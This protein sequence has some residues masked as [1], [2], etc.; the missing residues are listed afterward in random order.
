MA[1][2]LRIF[3]ID[4]QHDRCGD[5]V[6]DGGHNGL[7]VSSMIG[8]P[9]RDVFYHLEDNWPDA[10]VL[11]DIPEDNILNDFCDQ[12]AGCCPIIL[13]VEP[14][15]EK[16]GLQ[17][18]QHGVDDL[19]FRD[20]DGQ[21]VARL[22]FVIKK[23]LLQIH[24]DH[25]IRNL[26]TSRHYLEGIVRISRVISRYDDPL[27]MLRQGAGIMLDV[28]QADRIW[29]L[30]HGSSS[31]SGVR[32][33]MEI[34]RSAYAG[35][36]NTETEMEVKLGIS[37]VLQETLK[38][39]IPAVR[40]RDYENP[41]NKKAAA[42]FSIQS[43]ICFALRL[44]YDQP[45]LLCMHQCARKRLWN[46]NRIQLFQDICDR[47]RDALDHR[48]LLASLKKDIAKR[49]KIEARLVESKLRFKSLF[50]SSGIALWLLDYSQLNK[51]LSQ[52]RRYSVTD[53]DRYIDNNSEF[54]S[55]AASLIT[56]IDINDAT[57]KLCGARRKEDITTSAC[58]I[59]TPESSP[60]FR[61]LL[62]A[63]FSGKS[64]F[65]SEGVQRNFKGKKFDVLM[66]V[67]ILPR[68]AD[69]RQLLL[70]IIDISTLKK[71]ERALHE[72]QERYRQLLDASNDAIIVADA[73]TGIIVEANS[74]LVELTGKALYQIIG[75]HH[76]VLHPSMDHQKYN[77]SFRRQVQESIV[78]DD[79]D[80]YLMHITG[81]KVPV[82]I[83]GS[84]FKTKGRRLVQRNFHDISERK[85]AEQHRRL[86]YT[87]IEQADETI[88]ITT[89]EGIIVYVNPA[90]EWTSGYSRNEVI[91]E[92]SRILNSGHQD[93]SFYEKMWQ[94]ISSGKVWHG[95]F[96]NKKKEGSLYEEEV[97]ISPVRDEA[98]KITH[99]VAVKRD[100]SEQIALERQIR[101]SQK[102]DAI[103][104]L[105]TG[106]AHDFNN[107]LMQIVG[108]TEMSMDLAE[109]DSPLKKNLSIIYE[110][111]E[112]A[113]DL[114]DQILTFSSHTEK[115]EIPLR[116]GLIVKK[117]LDLLNSTMPEHIELKQQIETMKMTNMDPIQAHQIIMNLCTNAIQALGSRKGSI[118]V[119]LKDYEVDR[120]KAKLLG[121]ISPGQYLRLSIS[122]NGPGI[123]P[124]VIERIFEPYFSTKEKSKDRGT[125]L[126]LATI[127]GIA[128]RLGGTVSVKS[129]L[130]QGSRFDVYFPQSSAKEIL[131]QSGSKKMPTG[132]ERVVVVD[133]DPQVI[134]Y[135]EKELGRLGYNVTGFTSSLKVLDAICNNP[136]AYD[137]MLTDMTMPSLSG[138]RLAEEIRKLGNDMPIILCTEFS[139]HAESNTANIKGINAYLTKPISETRL[140][141]EVRKALDSTLPSI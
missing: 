60:A 91:G 33:P 28:F 109:D 132:S 81:R 40:D 121:N 88:I 83:S 51:L 84:L 130:G 24:G 95:H 3:Y 4:S 77:E 140:A 31:T 72:S 17:A 1:Q 66:S 128:V 129:T 61:Q 6:S 120:D 112:R 20:H 108:F 41:A 110:A 59:L 141:Q 119:V 126:G 114:V 111:S 62:L 23:T 64:H 135:I 68:H 70:N 67:D 102:M 106:I 36:L 124:E 96:T 2:K 90:F 26:Q 93:A 18:I 125:G 48:L 75:M 29:L 10:I 21:W 16:A 35:I 138:P 137:I 13:L 55:Q 82:K 14:G 115:N 12:I 47:L 19:V 44:K 11:A 69:T 37:E 116:L 79:G 27:E 118:E 127:H 136:E 74:R 134:A 133:D 80:S 139:K 99:Y 34:S 30:H 46:K 22:S 58:P 39:K 94:Q 113:G 7:I 122:D 97:T 49:Q 76:S 45:W 71:T 53:L 25:R 57:T 131:Q 54:L 73:E 65:V 107:I 50:S 15:K 43:Q 52:L 56:L 42:T 104:T 5:F 101:R 100:V 8:K 32:E 123:S 92:N 9:D 38:T 86:L 105:A 117:E 89:A 87:A 78:H 85:K 98:G 103:G 63:L